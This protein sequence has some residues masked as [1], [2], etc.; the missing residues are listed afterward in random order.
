MG[1][2][3]SL[4][5]YVA[6]YR[7]LQPNVSRLFSSSLCGGP[8]WSPDGRTLV[9]SLQPICSTVDG[10]VGRATADIDNRRLGLGSRL[11]RTAVP[12]AKAV[13]WAAAYTHLS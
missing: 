9:V 11:R 7:D 5:L 2:Q 3:R 8:V 6:G 4:P 1:E 10:D 13:R 12:S